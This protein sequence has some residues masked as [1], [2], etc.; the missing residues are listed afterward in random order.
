M[1]EVLNRVINK[2]CPQILANPKRFKTYEEAMFNLSP[3]EQMTLMYNKAL[4][5]ENEKS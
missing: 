4:E 2:R 3:M 1:V 5:I